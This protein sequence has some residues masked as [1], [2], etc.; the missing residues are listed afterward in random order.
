MKSTPGTFQLGNR[1]GSEIP[2][3]GV[4]QDSSSKLE[5][6]VLFFDP[7]LDFYEKFINLLYY[8]VDLLTIQQLFEFV[9]QI[10]FNNKENY[11]SSNKE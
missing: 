4:L 6:K 8:T 7:Q 10:L 3:E 2:M 1:V 5:P 11:C 9:H